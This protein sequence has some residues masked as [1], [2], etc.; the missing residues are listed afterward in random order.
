M[1]NSYDLY[2]TLS[3]PKE[4]YMLQKSKP[5]CLLM[6]KARGDLLFKRKKN[7]ETFSVLLKGT[8]QIILIM[9]VKQIYR[10]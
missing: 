10:V 7:T 8:Q 5:M 9:R 4:H 2:L 1:I 3:R 6:L